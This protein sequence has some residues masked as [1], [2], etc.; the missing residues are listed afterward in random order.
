MT[1]FANDADLLTFEPRAFVDLAGVARTLLQVDDGQLSGTTLTSTIG[2]FDALM[3]GHVLVLRSSA[4]DAVAAAVS[5]VTDT[6]TLELASPP[7]GL[8]AMS[9][10]SVMARTFAAQAQH[11]NGQLLRAIGI[12]VDD[13][14]CTLNAASVVSTG[15][16]RRLEVLGT[17]ALAYQAAAG[18]IG[19]DDEYADRAVGYRTR[20]NRALE[21]ARVLI[22]T[23]GDGLADAWRTPAAGSLVRM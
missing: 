22:D 6:N 20:F 12:E 1:T 16:M 4:A 18:P 10:L 8:A 5:Q 17:L 19:G 15:L 9:N 14:A 23:D 3:P 11:V 7:E 21:S 13:P 2:G